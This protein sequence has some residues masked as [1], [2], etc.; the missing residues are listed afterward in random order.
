M[1]APRLIRKSSWRC[2]DEVRE[3][4]AVIFAAEL[5]APSKE[6]WIVSPWISDIAVLDNRAGEFRGLDP[7]LPRAELRLTGALLRLLRQGTRVVVATRPADPR[8]SSFGN[9]LRQA[10][11]RNGLGHVLAVGTS[12]DLHEKGIL[13]DDFYLSGS[14]NLTYNGVEVL[15]E[16]VRFE[17]SAAV[18]ADSRISLRKFWESRLAFGG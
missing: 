1:S 14:M 16:I 9:D 15:E 2:Q 6:F 13:C 8:Y 12:D 3:L 4:I 17:T 5:F 7:N 18:I 10:A 11:D